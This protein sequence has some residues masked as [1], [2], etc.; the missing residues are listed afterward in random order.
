MLPMTKVGALSDLCYV[1]RN[2]YIE[3]FKLKKEDQDSNLDRGKDAEC[4]RR[5]YLEVE[6][7]F[8]HQRNLDTKIT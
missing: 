5:G 4:R 7:R 8:F 3:S 6:P 2:T 1:F